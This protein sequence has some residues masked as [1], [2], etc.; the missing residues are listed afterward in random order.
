MD[1]RLRP[2]NDVSDV[3]FASADGVIALAI[4]VELGHALGHAK[5]V[6]GAATHL[7]ASMARSASTT[8]KFIFF[9]PTCHVNPSKNSSLLKQARKFA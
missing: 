7:T 1:I 9:D 6:T 3:V 2:D 4:A 8:L 5:C